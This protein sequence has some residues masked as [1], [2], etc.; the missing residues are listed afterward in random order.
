MV[1]NNPLKI[2]RSSGILELNDNLKLQKK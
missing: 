1:D 2:W